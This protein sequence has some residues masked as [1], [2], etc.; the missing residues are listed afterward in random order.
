MDPYVFGAVA[1]SA[2]AVTL[3]WFTAWLA[4]SVNPAQLSRRLQQSIR[5]RPAAERSQ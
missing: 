3:L 5:D 2:L 1:G 4:K